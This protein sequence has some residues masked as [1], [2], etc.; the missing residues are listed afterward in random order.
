MIR[1]GRYNQLSDDMQ[2]TIMSLKGDAGVSTSK[3]PQV[4]DI[5]SKNLFHQTLDSPHWTTA[6]KIAEEAHAVAKIHVA[7]ALLENKTVTLHSDG[8]SREKKKFVGQQIALDNG[9]TLSLGFVEV[10]PEDAQTLLE[11][12]SNVLMELSELV[13]E[14]ETRGELLKSMLRKVCTT[15]SNRAAIMKSFN[16]KFDEM[17][18]EIVGGEIQTNFIYCNA[19]CLLGLSGACEEGVKEVESNMEQPLGRD[20]DSLF[21]KLES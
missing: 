12:T 8:T 21:K 16:E 14:E 9:R 7:E 15:M 17:R 4:I 3:Y 11:V 13:G 18:R 10:A 5:V 20:K 6:N 19:H 2:K 1:T